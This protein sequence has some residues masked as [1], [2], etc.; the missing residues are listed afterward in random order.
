MSFL[1][2]VERELRVASRKRATYRIRFFLALAGFLLWFTLLIGSKRAGISERG[3]ILFVAMGVLGL[4]FSMLAG[5]FL[6]SD[7]L[8]EERREGTLGLLF[9]T[10]LKGYD[11]VLGKL[12]ATSLHAF[13]G[14]LAIL[15]LLALPLLMGGV[16]GGEFWR[17]TLA[18]FTAILFSLALGMLASSLTH[19]SRQAI[20]ITLF[21]LVVLVGVLPA[22]WWADQGFGR[23]N[24]PAALRWASPVHLYAAA[25]DSFYNAASGPAE[26]Q[27]TW[28]TLFALIL[29]GLSIASFHL[30]RAWQEKHAQD[31]RSPD[32][33]RVNWWLRFGSPEFRQRRRWLLEANPMRWLAS[34]DRLPRWA[35]SLSLGV[36]SLVWFGFVAGCFLGSS[37]GRDVCFGVTLIMSYILHQLLKTYVIVESTRRL[38]EDKRSGALELLLVSPLTAEQVATGIKSAL[39]KTFALPLALVLLLNGTLFFLIVSPN[40]LHIDGEAQA[41][42][43]EMCVCGAIL[44]ILDIAASIRVGMAMALK[45][46]KQQRAILATF[47]RIMLLP[48]LATLFLFFLGPVLGAPMS[49]GDIFSLI[50]IWFFGCALLDLLA[51]ARANTIVITHLRSWFC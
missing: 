42:Y 16:T 46:S 37:T 44:L 39:V 31:S 17:V 15:P 6:T 27:R 28:W 47:L 10:P 23:I 41:V 2:I 12:L 50:F 48:W 30:P 45:K 24:A 25:F 38:S 43:G 40:P 51:A 35:I 8:S 20:S 33:P 22:V 11:V 49:T 1:P 21:G 7:C 34:R 14:L 18:L 5:I 26:F 4:G 32:P 36:L 29:G 3:K 13:Y 19:D 9:L